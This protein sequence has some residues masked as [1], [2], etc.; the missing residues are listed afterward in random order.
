MTPAQQCRA[1]CGLAQND[2]RTMDG[3]QRKEKTKDEKEQERREKETAHIDDHL[4]TQTV[5]GEVCYGMMVVVIPS[6]SRK[7]H[8]YDIGCVF[9]L[10]V[11]G[12]RDA[13]YPSSS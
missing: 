7:S 5:M 1:R 13:F 6:S 4:K 12:Y 10:I 2:G 9:V 11:P 3:P 8:R